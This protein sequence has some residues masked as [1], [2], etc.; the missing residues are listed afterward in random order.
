ML[1]SVSAPIRSGRHRETTDALARNARAV[2]MLISARSAPPEER[3]RLHQRVVLDYLDVAHA[4][5]GRYRTRTQDFHDLQQV[6]Y[7]GLTKAVKRFEPD[8]GSDIVSFVVPTISGEIKRYLR[9]ATWAVRPP[10]GLQELRT[11]LRTA[12]SELAQLLGREPTPEEL[13]EE[14]GHPVEVVAE[15]LRCGQGR[16][17]LSLDASVASDPDDHG[18]M[19]LGESLPA[20]ST[21][22]E[23]AD[24]ALAV[25]DACSALTPEERRIVHLRFFREFTQ[26]Q[27]ARECGVSQMQVSRLL[28]RIL[29]TLRERMSVSPLAE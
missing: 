4:V 13:A 3:V 8:R 17:P 9:D 6:A 29:R 21:D 20:P 1:V 25:A 7:V 23:D 5:A 22:F 24:L 10:R 27:I 12:S 2:A 15:A 26:E 14:T 11:E 16:R 19:T 28:K 18:A